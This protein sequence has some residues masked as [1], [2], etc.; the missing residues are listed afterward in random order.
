MRSH[1]VSNFPD[2]NTGDSGF[3]FKLTAGVNP[4]SPAFKSGL[5]ACHHYLPGSLTNPHPSESDQKAMLALARCLREHGLTNVPDPTSTPP[6]PGTGDVIGR[7]GVFLSLPGGTARSPAFQQAAKAC[8]FGP[9]K[10][11][12]SLAP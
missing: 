7:G 3:A 2:P 8:G 5:Q 1:G 6:N 4:Q 9:G 12:R 11:T 10:P